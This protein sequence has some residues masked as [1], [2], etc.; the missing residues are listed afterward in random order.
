VA[1]NRK[2]LQETLLRWSKPLKLAQRRKAGRSERVDEDGQVCL[3]FS[4]IPLRINIFECP[5]AEAVRSQL[6]S[7]ASFGHLL[8]DVELWLI[9]IQSCWNSIASRHISLCAE[10]NNLSEVRAG[11]GIGYPGRRSRLQL[12]GPPFP[13][14]STTR[15]TTLIITNVNVLPPVMMAFTT[16][17]DVPR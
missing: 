13:S 2:S 3:P 8:Y 4:I 1:Y 5:V 15:S 10:P 11:G 16:P 6:R 17:F 9:G 12:E 7:R 14:T